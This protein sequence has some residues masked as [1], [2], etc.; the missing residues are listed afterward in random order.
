M[1]EF[2][3]KLITFA[4]MMAQGGG[5]VESLAGLKKKLDIL[6]SQ[7]YQ[8]DLQI[9]SLKQEGNTQHIPN[10]RSRNQLLTPKSSLN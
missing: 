6:S 10:L 4:L 8:I 1:R 9:Y 7:I 3:H 5:V 2:S